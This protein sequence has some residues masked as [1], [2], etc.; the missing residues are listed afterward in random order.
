MASDGTTQFCPRC[1][2]KDAKIEQLQENVVELGTFVEVVNQHVGDDTFAALWECV[3]DRPY[4][5]FDVDAHWVWLVE[6]PRQR[7]LE[8]GT[9]NPSPT[10][11]TKEDI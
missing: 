11:P 7:N 2:E 3:F 10:T 6:E 5:S 4:R 9:P 1:V 8:S